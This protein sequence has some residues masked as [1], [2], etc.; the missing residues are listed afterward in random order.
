MDLTESIAFQYLRQRGI[1]DRE[2]EF[3]PDG[4]VPPDFLV[5]GEVAVE[6]RRL[7]QN[8]KTPGGTRGVQTIPTRQSVSEFVKTIGPPAPEESWWVRVTILRRPASLKSLKRSIRSELAA[9]LEW[10]DRHDEHTHRFTVGGLRLELSRANGPHPSVFVP[11]SFVDR[12]VGGFVLSELMRNIPICV[13]EKREKVSQYRARY[14]EWWLILVDHVHGHLEP[15]EEQELRSY[16][17]VPPDWDRVAIV[18][19]YDPRC[20]LEFYPVR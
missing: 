15:Y 11:A 14:P 9:F 2:V 17:R 18:S 8:E 10:P 6:V 12:R 13:E 7:N 16:V 1:D 3:E 20:S 19:A 5:R 4:N